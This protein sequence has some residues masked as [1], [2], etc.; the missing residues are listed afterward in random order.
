M[1]RKVFCHHPVHNKKCLPLIAQ[2][3]SKRIFLQFPSVL[4][5]NGFLHFPMH[6]K[7]YFVSFP[8]AYENAIPHVTQCTPIRLSL[9]PSCTCST[10][11]SKCMLF[12]FLSAHHNIFSCHFPVHIQTP[13]PLIPLCTPKRL[14]ASFLSALRNVLFYPSPVNVKTSLSPPSQYTS[15]RHSR[16]HIKAS[17]L[18]KSPHKHNS[19]TV[20][21][22][23]L[24]VP[25]HVS[26]LGYP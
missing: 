20:V 10:V 17:I 13:F 23:H 12:S 21:I 8:S 19:F 7:M 6:M 4:Q 15:K 25:V 2:H 22:A 11:Q 14:F 9:P 26:P 16:A 24:Q 3:V 1:R 5:T 18:S